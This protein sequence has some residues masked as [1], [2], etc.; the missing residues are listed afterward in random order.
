[1]QGLGGIKIIKI[2]KKEKNFMN[3][4][5][6]HN[7]ENNFYKYL[8]NFIT[9]LPRFILEIIVV[10][11]AAFAMVLLSLRNI[12]ST[13][14]FLKASVFG[15]AALRMLPSLNRIISSF[16]KF[17]VCKF[18]INTV[19][20]QINYPFLSEGRESKKN[21]LINLDKFK[22]LSLENI[23]FKFENSDKYILKNI[24]FKINKGEYIGI[25]GKTGS[26]KSTLIDL[27]TGL[28]EPSSGSVNVNNININ[29]YENWK[30]KIG[31]V[32]Q[33]IYLTDDTLK[34]NIAFGL[35][36]NEIDENQVLKSIDQANLN[37]FL[38]NLE[39]GIDEILGERGVKISGGE[40][41]RIGL[42]RAIYND[43]E[44]LIFDEFTSSLDFKTE[45][46]ILNNILR[47]KGEKTIIIISHK[48]STLKDCDRV[49]E[50]TENKIKEN[51]NYAK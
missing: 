24:S 1:M 3:I 27:I 18:Q 40:M 13:E 50:V 36:E 16:E 20:T 4:F 44:L 12:P 39:N 2:L 28:I 8:A 33:F 9:N 32:P 47:Y 11:F 37:Y 29:R 42:S 43:P 17:R 7:S 23:D 46:E 6:Q 19:Y 51:R 45:E 48:L 31:Y 35:D 15:F 22:N 25:V 14:I 10:I 30:T 26:G 41:Q 34:K 5:N 38:K 49:I 21:E